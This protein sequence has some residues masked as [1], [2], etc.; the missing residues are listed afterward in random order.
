MGWDV[1]LADGISMPCEGGSFE[2]GVQ[3]TYVKGTG[4]DKMGKW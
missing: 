4:P 2:Y 3:N 1:W